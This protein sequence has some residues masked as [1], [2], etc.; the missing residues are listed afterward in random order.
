MHGIESWHC[1]VTNHKNYNDCPNHYIRINNNEQKDFTLRN[2]RAVVKLKSSKPNKNKVSVI[3]LPY[4]RCYDC[5]DSIHIEMN[6]IKQQIKKQIDHSLL[7]SWKLAGW[8]AG[9][10]RHRIQTSNTSDMQ[11]T[12]FKASIHIHPQPQSSLFLLL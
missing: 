3:N 4:H 12:H 11:Q 5:Y 10:G 9:S 8:V 1:T 2:L 6:G 7:G